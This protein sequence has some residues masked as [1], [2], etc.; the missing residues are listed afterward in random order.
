MTQRFLRR[1]AV[2]DIEQLKVVASIPVGKSPHGVFMMKS[3]AAGAGKRAG[4]RG[5]DGRRDQVGRADARPH[6]PLGHRPDL[7]LRDLRRSGHFPFRADGLVRAGLQRRR[8]RDAGRGPDR[9]HRH[10]H[11]LL[12]APLAAREIGQGRPA[13]PGRPGLHGAEQARHRSAGHLRHHLSAGSGDRA[14]GAGLGICAAAAGAGAAVAG[15]QRAGLVPALFRPLR[16][17]GLLAAPRA[18]RASPGGGRCT[19]C[20]TASAG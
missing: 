9:G 14:D 17:R 5:V 8:V 12:R 10:R 13:D 20:I 19:A 4:A 18:A 11:A 7:D 2:V 16:F 15:R 1:V 6:R 3:G